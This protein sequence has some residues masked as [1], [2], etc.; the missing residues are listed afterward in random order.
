Q[1]LFNCLFVASIGLIWKNLQKDFP[2]LHE[3]MHS[4]PWFL[5]KALHCSFCFTYWFS[6]GLVLFQNPSILP[7][8]FPSF[9]FAWLTLSFGSYCFYMIARILYFTME[10][11]YEK[12]NHTK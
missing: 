12:T 5:K 9:L 4:L 11:L 1:F 7:K 3:I 6:L 8:K 2:S 10:Y